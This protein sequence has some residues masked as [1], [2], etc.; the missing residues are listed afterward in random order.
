[1]VAASAVRTGLFI[2]V[3]LYAWATVWLLER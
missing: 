3:A 1:V 2:A